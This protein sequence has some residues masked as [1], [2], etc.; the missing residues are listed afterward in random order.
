MELTG[1]LQAKLLLFLEN[2]NDSNLYSEDAPGSAHW[3]MF[4]KLQHDSSHRLHK[5]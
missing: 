5:E 3:G 4:E 2:V 1:K